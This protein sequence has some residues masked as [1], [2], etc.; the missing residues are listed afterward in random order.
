MHGKKKNKKPTKTRMSRIINDT[1]TFKWKL[2][3]KP[4][5]KG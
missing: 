5:R 2:R 4:S 3:H 1:G